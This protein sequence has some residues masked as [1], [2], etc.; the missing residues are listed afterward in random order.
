[1]RRPAGDGRGPTDGRLTPAHPPR[2][3]GQLLTHLLSTVLQEHCG[4]PLQSG[5]ET[6]QMSWNPHPLPVHS[7]TRHETPWGCAGH[8]SS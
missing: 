7:G 8:R 3:E 5:W 1:M 6:S 2:Y 4:H